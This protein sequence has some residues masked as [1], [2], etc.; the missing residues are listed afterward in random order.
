[1][2]KPVLPSPSRLNLPGPRATR[3]YAQICYQ[4]GDVLAFG[5]ES[6]GLPQSMLE[7]HADRTVRI[8]IRREVRSLNL[9]NSVAIVAF[10]ALRQWTA[11]RSH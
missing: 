8:P 7:Q 11:A 10:E 9:S 2:Y 6:R 4:P 3:S 1:M 5:N